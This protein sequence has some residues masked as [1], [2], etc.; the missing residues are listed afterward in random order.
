MYDDGESRGQT[1]RSV[2]FKIVLVVL[3]L[4][5]L[6]I[7]FPTKGFVKNYV[8][9]KTGSVDNFNS[10]LI[11]MATAGSGY[12]TSSR[13]PKDEGSKVVL[14]L[15]EMYNKKMLVKFSDS[16]K[17]ACNLKKSYIE[18]ERGTDE[19]TMKVNLSCSDKTDYI[20]LHMGLDDT[21]FPSTST[22]RCEFLK[23]LDDASA[24]GEWSSWST[25]KIEKTSTNQVET[26]VSKVQSGTR[27]VTH[28]NVLEQPAVKMN[29]NGEIIYVCAVGYNNAGSYKSMVNCRKTLVSYS[30][31]AVYKKVVYYRYRDVISGQTDTKWADCDNDELIKQGYVKT[32]K[33]G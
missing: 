10:N 3:V 4:F 20:V 25:Q 5:V 9:S 18:V 2:F 7:L 28:S 22:A 19:Y 15:G 16:N 32:G 6:M 12:F 17:K 29:Y 23:N 21:S 24:Y 30:D 27:R 26:K 31:E 1:L 13:L 33:T 14:T 8:D 11:A